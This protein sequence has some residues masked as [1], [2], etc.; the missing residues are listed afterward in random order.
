MLR[1]LLAPEIEDDLDH[2]ALIDIVHRTIDT[3]TQEDLQDARLVVISGSIAPH[4]VTVEML[5]EYAEQGGQL[6]ITAG[7][8]FDTTSWTDAAW[9]QGD[10]ILPLAI[11]SDPIGSLPPIS[12]DDWPQFKLD[13]KT[14]DD[15]LYRFE[16]SSDELADLILTPSFYK[17]VRADEASLIDWDERETVRIEERLARD[18]DQIR[19]L[20]WTNP[21]ARHYSEFS[22]KQLVA[23]N[24]PQPLGRYQSGEPFL[25]QR[26]MGQGHIMFL[27]SGVFPEWNN[28]ALD[29][30]VL[31]MDRILRQLLVRS[32]P[33]RTLETRNEMV[34]PVATR[35]QHAS[36]VLQWPHQDDSKSTAVEV[37]GRQKYGVVL[38]GASHR[39]FYELFRANEG[40]SEQA[41]VM[42]LGFNGP[43]TES[44]IQLLDVEELQGALTSDKIRWVQPGQS[45]TLQG[46]TYLGSGTWKWLMYLLLI[47][48]L[49]E[50]ILLGKKRQVDDDEQ[51]VISV[52][53][54][55][56]HPK[57]SEGSL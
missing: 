57:T 55:Q 3:L 33:E 53:G 31:I 6:L 56:P 29:A 11:M 47:V 7:G 46:T 25:V 13:P 20:N 30:G 23:R 43:S 19:W 21:L 42:L 45:I 22:V 17:A 27:T 14:F 54:R 1:H 9:I 18:D 24:R 16:L 32:L 51:S 35:Y 37:L 48:L 12:A 39:G 52:S 44:N 41:A 50:M 34:I 5:R 2:Q 49:V 26:R 4:H 15:P 28:L 10:G 40:E 8:L 38:R 36:H